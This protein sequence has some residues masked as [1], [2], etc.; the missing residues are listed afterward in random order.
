MNIAS[1]F[2]I[3]FLGDKKVDIKEKIG[4]RIKEARLAKGLT[5][6]QL[7]EKTRTLKSSRI[8]NWEQGTR[9]PG[10]IETMQLSNALG[11]SPA[12]LLCLSDEKQKASDLTYTV[13]LYDINSI[14]SLKSI[15]KL[16]PVEY[17]SINESLANRL[18]TAAFAIAL[19]D[20][21][22]EPSF[23][24]KDIVIIDPERT[25]NPGDYVLALV[26]DNTKKIPLFR[27]YREIDAKKT[28]FTPYELI[29]IN[30]DWASIRATDQK[31]SQILG[32]LVELRRTFY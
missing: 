22:M 25:P 24:K 20:N 17:L 23:Y 12:Y 10:P 14:Q 27:K 32:S 29:A 31:T 8:G 19:V 5:V 6:K 7:A 30:E 16:N 2:I 21:S 13:P 4:Q 3:S 15:E 1:V 28:K 11:I 9:S 26:K 18:S